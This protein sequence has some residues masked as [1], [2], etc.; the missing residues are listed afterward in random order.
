MPRFFLAKED[1]MKKYM[2]VIR[3]TLLLVI[4]ALFVPSLAAA[5]CTLSIGGCPACMTAYVDIHNPD[6]TTLYVWVEITLLREGYYTCAWAGTCVQV[7]QYSTVRIYLR[8]LNLC[9]NCPTNLTMVTAQ[10]WVCDDQAHCNA[11][12]CRTTWPDCWDAWP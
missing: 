4:C 5:A 10:A 7:Q 6:A 9:D 2:S 1:V 12:D 3:Q 11:S 8:D